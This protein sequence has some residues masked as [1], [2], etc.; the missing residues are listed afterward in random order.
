M[1]L[2]ALLTYTSLLGFIYFG[3]IV[4]GPFPGKIWVL[5]IFY[6]LHRD[7]DVENQLRSLRENVKTS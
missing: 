6:P 1:V 5:G 4:A 2:W 3:M 7:G